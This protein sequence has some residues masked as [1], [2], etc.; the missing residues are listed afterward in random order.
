MKMQSA[1]NRQ[2]LPQKRNTN[3][4]LNT[5]YA[6]LLLFTHLRTKTLSIWENSLNIDYTVRRPASP[7]P[8]V[9]ASNYTF[10]AL[11]RAT[12]GFKCPAVVRKLF[13]GTPALEKWPTRDYLPS[14]I[15]KDFVLPVVRNSTYNT[16]QKERV[17]LTFADAFLQIFEEQSKA[18]LF[19]PIQSRFQL[20]ETKA[21]KNK[22]EELQKTVNQL[23]RDDLEL[24]RIW[25]GFGTANHKTY[26]GSQLVIGYGHKSSEETTGTG[27]HC[28]V[29]NNYFIQVAGRKRWYFISPHNSRY[30]HPLRNGLNS[31]M[32]GTKRM[33]QIQHHTPCLYVDL[34]P[35][36]LLYNPYWQWH[37]VM[38]YEG[39]SIGVP[40]REFKISEAFR[41]NPLYTSIVGINNLSVK[42]FKH[43]IGGY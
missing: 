26:V 42:L 41:H 36:D 29:S 7:I 10:E 19:F 22:S 3:S 33:S 40:I 12:D 4:F 11:K 25:Q 1:E 34:E 8:E 13:Q 21:D 6:N 31:M 35:G 39:L 24:D 27:W 2:S 5:L 37:T 20:N 28:A 30:L 9:D 15:I 32:T 18:Y 17:D 23:I 43:D 16:A 38:N 14:S